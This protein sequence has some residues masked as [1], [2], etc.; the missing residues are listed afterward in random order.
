ML[1]L[2]VHL[3]HAL[4]YEQTNLGHFEDTNMFFQFLIHELS[5]SI[6]RDTSQYAY[7][8]LKSIEVCVVVF[9]N[10][11]KCFVNMWLQLGAK[12][13]QDDSADQ[14]VE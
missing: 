5:L 1:N 14:T 6:M 13:L 10:G 8:Y 11:Y 3:I 12:F 2:D 9:R 4:I 7:T